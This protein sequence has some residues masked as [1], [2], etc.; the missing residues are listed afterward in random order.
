MNKI[1][2]CIL[3]AF[4]SVN[5]AW[6][7][8]EF[9]FRHFNSTNTPVLN[10][11]NFKAVAVTKSG[12]I[13]AG[14][15]YHGLLKYDAVA[16][17][18]ARSTDITDV[19][20]TDIKTTNTEGVWLTQSGRS[21]S[22]GGGSNIA[23][24]VNYFAGPVSGTS[25]YSITAPGALT[26]RNARSVWVDKKRN[27]P[28]GNPR[29]WVAQ[30]TYTSS[31][32]T[33]AGGISV[34]LNTAANFF[35]KVYKGLQVTPNVP[36]AQAGTPNCISVGGYNE[37]VWVCAL[38]NFGRSQLLR[39]R[40]DDPGTFIGAYDYTNTP[41]LSAGFRA[42]AIFTDNQHRAWLGLNENGL[43]IK[44]L[45]GWKT[46]NNPILLP[47]GTAVYPNAIC[48]DERGYIYFGTSSGLLIYK[49]GAVDSVSSYQ[50]VTM[51]DGLVSNTVNGVAAD[52]VN[53]RIILAHAAGIS[54]LKFK[55]KISSELEWDYSFPER[56]GKPLAVAADGVA[57]VFLKVRRGISGRTDLKKVKIRVKR[58][59]G[60][61]ASLSGLV[62]VANI[63]DKYSNEANTG[64]AFEAERSDSTSKGDFYFW[65]VAPEDFSA[66]S[67]GNLAGLGERKDTVSIRVTYSDNSEDST[68]M[69]IK[70]VRPPL[71]I[72]TMVT[73]AAEMVQSLTLPNGSS[74]TESEQFRVRTQQLNAMEPYTNIE[75][76]TMQETYER[77]NDKSPSFPNMITEARRDGMAVS[78]VDFVAQGASGNVV[79]KLVK[80]RRKRFN[81]DTNDPTAYKNYGKGYINKFITVN[82]PHNGSPLLQMIHDVN[83]PGNQIDGRLLGLANRADLLPMRPYTLIS[84]VAGQSQLVRASVLFQTNRIDS[85]NGMA[86]TD[87]KNHLI[88]T[89]LGTAGESNLSIRNRMLDGLTQYIANDY[90]LM[91]RSPDP[92][93]TYSNSIIGS[94]LPPEKKVD[95]FINIYTL[96]TNAEA[97][98]T[99]VGD[100]ISSLSSQLAGNSETVGH[101]TKKIYSDSE[102]NDHE[103]SL[104]NASKT[105]YNLLN[106]AINSPA[107]ANS[108]PA[109]VSGVGYSIGRMVSTQSTVSYDTA[110]I[111]IINRDELGPSSFRQSNN[112]IAT[113]NTTVNDTTITVKYI[114]KDTVRLAHVRIHFQAQNFVTKSRN[115]NQELKI[116]V[117]KSMLF[118]GV[119]EI[120]AVAV[121]Q[122]QDSIQYHADTLYRNIAKPD[123]LKGF[124]ILE[125]EVDIVSGLTY[126]PS[127][128]VKIN[129][130]WE[131]VAAN[132]PDITYTIENPSKINFNSDTY[133]FSAAAD[134]YSRIYFQY[135]TYRDTVA[136]TCQLPYS[137]LAVNRTIASGSFKNAATWSKGRAPYP[138]DSVI[139]ST[140]HTVTLDTTLQIRSLKIE[141]GAVLNLN[142]NAL[143]LQLGDDEDGG[144]MIDNYGT[145]NISNG[146]LRVS[147]RIKSNPGSIYAMSGGTLVIDGNTG[148]AINSLQNG[149]YLFEAA[150]GMQSFSF[151]GGT[152]QLV[153][154]PIGL[155]SQAI[156]C[157]YN[158]GINSTLLLGNGISQTASSSPNGFG[159]DGFPPQIGKLILDASTTGGNRLLKITKPLTVKGLFQIRTGSNL[160]LQ[161]PVT[162]SP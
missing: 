132:D 162:V 146:T 28:D 57:R 130:N 69:P 95:S 81:A 55:T 152:L 114:V 67:L 113:E 29:V 6:A 147:G 37:E 115:R 160:N 48:Q 19:L 124:R 51:V 54:F 109:T 117:D 8:S 76:E 38:A 94:D 125:D 62:R 101:V 99:R 90:S 56:T 13:W 39:Y 122:N 105:I 18:W 20:I 47:A 72:S 23:G 49:G 123:T 137:A 17:S 75:R 61:P 80:V 161:A 150:P 36:A 88:G 85:G 12:A 138:A 159:G 60:T 77:V 15:Q 5:N 65:F 149:M 116:T 82:T 128:E 84:R 32:T 120:T 126:I 9:E 86:Q 127:Y 71:V 140:G 11:N 46:M 2:L 118:S 16:D 121:Y 66:D 135:K 50:L 33:Q 153:D 27:G 43:I 92:I 110:K 158:F 136:V 26:S 79:R 119:Q 22:Q 157:P 14:S 142:N 103:T 74:I 112:G 87:I 97:N 78:R 102:K 4:L 1:L 31:S 70:I 104:G 73:R 100:R 53:N 93:F 25:F 83:T 134:G 108:I 21:G 10:G 35:T 64:T 154:P 139:I 24:G 156:N 41:A 34:G 98:F 59:T 96:I 52:T 144:F 106:T 129:D 7:Q 133:D 91:T 145:L 111:V 68:D 151:T 30:G 42:N 148:D 44:T 40:A 155:A 45:A 3:L 107:F 63:I 89:Q 143:A 131:P 141:T 58:A